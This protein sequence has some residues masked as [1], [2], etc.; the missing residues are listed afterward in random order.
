MWPSDVA[1]RPGRRVLTLACLTPHIHAETADLARASL[2]HPR[3]H[4]LKAIAA[5]AATL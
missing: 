3:D 1:L 4:T 2:S 5:S